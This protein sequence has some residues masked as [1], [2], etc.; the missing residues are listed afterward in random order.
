[1][2]EVVSVLKAS[3]WGGALFLHSF[4]LIAFAYQLEQRGW[5]PQYNTSVRSEAL[6]ALE[7]WNELK[8]SAG[9]WGVY[10]NDL[11]NGDRSLWE[12]HVKVLQRICPDCKLNSWDYE[13]DIESK[14]QALGDAEKIRTFVLW[15]WVGSALSIFVIGLLSLWGFMLWQARTRGPFGYVATLIL[16]M[17]FIVLTNVFIWNQQIQDCNGIRGFSCYADD[18]LFLIVG[19]AMLFISWPPLYVYARRRALARKGG[20]CLDEQRKPISTA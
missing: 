13:S 12:K 11:I 3:L 8:A 1:M 4:V 6:N 19:V 14:L 2:R 5:E 15:H 16:G 9:H 18:S 7:H 10:Q 17:P 20:E